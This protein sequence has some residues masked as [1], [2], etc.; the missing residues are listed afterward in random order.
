MYW[1]E[2]K[3]Q[4][5][6]YDFCVPSCPLHFM[7]LHKYWCWRGGNY[8]ALAIAVQA[9]S[10]QKKKKKPTKIFFFFLLSFTYG[11]VRAQC[12]FPLRWKNQILNAHTYLCEYFGRCANAFHSKNHTLGISF[13]FNFLQFKHIRRNFVRRYVHFMCAFDVYSTETNRYDRRRRLQYKF[14]RI[15]V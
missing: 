15:F 2:K 8:F 5:F 10:P 9:I 4:L 7:Y 1:Q 13:K 12:N 14:H 11:W 3:I 6:L